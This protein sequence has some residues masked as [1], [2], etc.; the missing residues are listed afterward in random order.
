[1][2]GDHGLRFHEDEGVLPVH[3]QSPHQDPEHSIG[4][5]D[6]CTL[7]ASPEDRELV[8]ESHILQRELVPRGNEGSEQREDLSQGCHKVHS[9]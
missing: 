9:T 4:V 5:P 8:T 6:P 7:H 2:P 1:M 3:E